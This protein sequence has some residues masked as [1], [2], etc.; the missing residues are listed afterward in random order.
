MQL[1]DAG[2][3]SELHGDPN[4]LPSPSSSSS[5]SGAGAGLGAGEAS[6]SSAASAAVHATTERHLLIAL[7]VLVVVLAVQGLYSRSLSMQLRDL[8]EAL[9]ALKAAV[10]QQAS[11]LEELEAL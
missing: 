1:A 11:A 4:A 8:T 3:V 9:A 6:I 10:E 2:V 5:P 7:A